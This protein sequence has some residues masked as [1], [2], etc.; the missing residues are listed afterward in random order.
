MKKDH[1]ALFTVSKSSL[2]LFGYNENEMLEFVDLKSLEKEEKKYLLNQALVYLSKAEKSPLAFNEWLSKRKV[3]AEWK[4]EIIGFM[5][6]K[7]ILCEARFAEA[8]SHKHLNRGGK[9]RWLIIKE[10]ESKQVS[11]LVAEGIDFDDNTSLKNYLKRHQFRFR[12]KKDK[13]I[14]S[15]HQ[16]G[17]SSEV[18]HQVVELF[19][20]GP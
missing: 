10:L 5:T 19:S 6:E 12:E 4:Q 8:Y 20:K 15:L 9:P 2:K 13:C 16:K 17:F 14:Q 7:N 1:E 11:K 18:V 3:I